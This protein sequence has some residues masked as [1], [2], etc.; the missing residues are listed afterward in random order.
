[1]KLKGPGKPWGTSILQGGDMKKGVIL[2]VVLMMVALAALAFAVPAGKTLTYEGK[3]MGQVRMN[4]PR[5]HAMMVSIVRIQSS[6]DRALQGYGYLGTRD[7]SSSL[8]CTDTDTHPATLSARPWELSSGRL[9][10][11]LDYPK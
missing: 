6:A 11:S 9:L 4:L 8:G 10:G 1:M 2:I 3:G 5:K 7:K